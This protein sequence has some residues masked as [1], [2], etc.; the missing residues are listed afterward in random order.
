MLPLPVLTLLSLSPLAIAVVLH[1]AEP[2]PPMGS[3]FASR[4]A[5]GG[6]SPAQCRAM[7]GRM[8]ALLR[9]DALQATAGLAAPEPLCPP[10]QLR[11]GRSW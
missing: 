7:A 1:V 3:G 4:C 11:G 6:L 5:A 2:P 10:S 8:A 9:Q